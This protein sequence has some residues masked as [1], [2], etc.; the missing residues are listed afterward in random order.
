MTKTLFEFQ[1]ST[2]RWIVEKYRLD[3]S[4]IG[5]GFRD[6][7]VMLNLQMDE[8]WMRWQRMG[9]TVF[10]LWDYFVITTTARI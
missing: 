8:L 9:L 1:C 7:L 3:F 2:I 6:A 4:E 10:L 5:R